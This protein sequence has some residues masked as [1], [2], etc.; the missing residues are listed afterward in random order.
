MEKVIFIQACKQGDLTD[1]YKNQYPYPPLGLISLSNMLKIHGIESVIYDLFLQNMNKSSLINIL[2]NENTPLLIGIS[3][4]TDSI[5]VACSI[6]KECKRIFP[7]TKVMLGGAHVTFMYEEVMNE[8]IDIDYCCIGE[9]EGA[10]VELVEYLRYGSIP[11]N[12]IKNI[13]YRDDITGR[14][15]I[16]ERRGYLT[17]MD[18]LPFAE[19]SE[20]MLDAM[21]ERNNIVI[22]S[23]RGCPGGCIFCASRKMSGSKYRYYTAEYLISYLFY[24]HKIYNFQTYTFLD[25]TFTANKRRLRKFAEYVHKLK[26]YLR[27]TC[28]SRADVI[29]EEMADLLSEIKCVSIHVGVESADNRILKAINKK[30]TLDDV[31]KAIKLL[32]LH[33]IRIECTFIIGHPQDTIET[34]EKTLIMAKML[35]NT[36]FSLSVIGVCTPFPG[37]ALWNHKDKLGMKILTHKWARYDLV[38]P[39][40]VTSNYSE[41]D[42]KKAYYY[43]SNALGDKDSLPGLSENTY[44]QFIQKIGGFITEIKKSIQV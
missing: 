37:T 17:N 4:Y 44:E 30:I 16:N 23:S 22:V 21:K 35:N 20:E 11:I 8:Y 33:G 12:G 15:M 1:K 7:N 10:I 2:Q 13:V 40:F 34:I 28:K 42:L 38:T 6:A 31:F 18:I 32:A 19:F 36:E 27:F 3:S 24:Y 41:A 29:D 26:F 14:V 25:D 9:G 39:I 43:F 5:D